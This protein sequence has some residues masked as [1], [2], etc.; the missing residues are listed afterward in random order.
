[1]Q[2]LE[3]SGGGATA[4]DWMVRRPAAQSGIE[5]LRAGLTL[6]HFSRHRHDTYTIAVTEQGVQEFGFRGAVH[7]SLPGQVVILHPDELHDGRPATPEGF[8][9][10]SLY[11]APGL[12]A[13]TLRQ[14]T[15][16]VRTL[17]FARTPVVSDAH[18]ARRLWH[19]C[20]GPLAPLEEVD[21]LRAVCGAL[22]RHAGDAVPAS[23]RTDL[24]DAAFARARE[25]LDA[26]FQHAVDAAA[27]ETICGESR[28]TIAEGFRRRQGTTPHRY[29]LMRRLDFV[30]SRLRS[31]ASLAELAAE[32]GFADQSHM[33]RHF[34]AAFGLTPAIHAKLTRDDG[35]D[36]TR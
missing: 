4:G 2:R 9:F 27:L 14:L 32:A 6:N 11:V 19:A 5:F 25:Y 15:G 3:R 16:R 13:D 35:R 24:S 18:L 7:R 33:T 31:G 26:H 30:R 8:T 20:T 23:R 29:L 10:R 28:Y 22:L 17:P 1:M 12:V 34:K 36:G 21:L